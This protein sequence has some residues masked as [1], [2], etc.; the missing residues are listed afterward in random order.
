MKIAPLAYSV[1]V[2]AVSGARAIAFRNE[3]ICAPDFA[4][5]VAEKIAVICNAIHSVNPTLSPA[6]TLERAEFALF[7][8]YGEKI[9]L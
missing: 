9:S 3:P 4:V 5:E 1:T 7:G 6:N 2:C 8:T